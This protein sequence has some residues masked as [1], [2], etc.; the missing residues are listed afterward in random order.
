MINLIY[1]LSA[2][3]IGYLATDALRG[4]G[5]AFLGC[6]ALAFLAG[7]CMTREYQRMA[8]RYQ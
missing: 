2:I 6:I 4:N 8:S 7:V 1:Y 3:S 5:W